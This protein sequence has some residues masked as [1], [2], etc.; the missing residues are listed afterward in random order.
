MEH[1]GGMSL[2]VRAVTTTTPLAI[3]EQRFRFGSA[4]SWGR[5]QLHS[6]GVEYK[7]KTNINFTTLPKA[8]W[9]DVLQKRA[10]FRPFDLTN[11]GVDDG[12][13]QLSS[14]R[15]SDLVNDIFA[16]DT[17]GDRAPHFAASFRGILALVQNTKTSDDAT[18]P[19]SVPLTTSNPSKATQ[20]R[21]ADDTAGEKDAKRTKV[22]PDESLP[23]GP[24]TPDQPTV[25]P[26]P[27]YSGSTDSSGGSLESTDEELTK[28]LIRSFLDDARGFL[29]LDFRVLD[30]TK[31]GLK[32]DLAIRHITLSM[33]LMQERI[34]RAF[35]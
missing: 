11:L 2:R 24:R 20:K 3:A 10:S 23:K 27:N 4:C 32:T 30:W 22:L 12:K 26:N 8:G 1:P 25:L 28:A 13:E 33:A 14:I 6:L 19:S 7:Q 18:K 34:R 9:S 31:S 29:R 5:R 17:I 21:A 35:D 15:V 16:E